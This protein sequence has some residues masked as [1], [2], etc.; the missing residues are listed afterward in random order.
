MATI[1]ITGGS[2]RVATLLRPFLRDAGHDVRLLDV[3]EPSVGLAD[4]E[5]FEVVD[6]TDVDALTD[7]IAGSDLLVHLASY[8]GERTWREIVDVNIES[9]HAVHEAAHRA[10]VGRVLAA[11]SV[12]AVGLV[13]NERA[14]DVI[15]PSPRPDSFYGVG[16]VVLEALGSLY[17][18]RHGTTVVSAR[19]MSAEPEPYDERSLGTWLSPADTARLVEAALTTS[20]RGHHIV[21]GVSHNTRRAVSLAA[22]H[23][24]GFYPQD[25]GETFAAN[26]P[27]A[28][29]STTPRPDVVG[30]DFAARP[31]GEPWD[32]PS[33]GGGAGR[34]SR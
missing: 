6:V 25:D 26:F 3:V 11:S 29:P 18:D 19:I 5:R 4:G 21:W 15:V 2:G 22:G 12:H 7:A 31:L 17:A 13:P 16:K 30:G 28:S 9:A 32:Q 27:D 23:R 10:G 14:R 1:S 24:I 20:E 33:E 8:P 34:V